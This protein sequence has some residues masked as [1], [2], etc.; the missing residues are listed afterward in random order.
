MIKKTVIFDLDG[1]LADIEPRRLISLK[2]NGKLNFGIFFDPKN[3]GLDMPNH[4]VI[5]A[6]KA[7]EAMGNRMVIFSGRSESMRD[8]TIDWLSE[9]GINPDLIIMRP[10]EPTSIAYMPDD[11]LKEM[12]LNQQFPTD[13]DKENILCVYDDRDKV[14]AMWRKNYITCFQVAPGDF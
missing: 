9:H 13:D 6:F 3:I 14:V 1:T 5:E 7:H 8:V 11:Q 2:D 10:T 12:W 4:P